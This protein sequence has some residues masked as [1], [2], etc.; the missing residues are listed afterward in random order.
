[1]GGAGVRPASPRRA[2]AREGC[3]PLRTP[4][5]P[6]AVEP[7][8]LRAPIFGAGV[9]PE[10]LA[11]GGLL[12]AFARAPAL[13]SGFFAA[14][15]ATLPAEE[16]RAMDDRPPDLVTVREAAR[17]VDRSPGTVRTWIRER[18]LSSWTGEGT[19]PGNAPILVSRAELL[20]LVVTEGAAAHPGRPP[21]SPSPSPVAPLDG[22][23][24]AAL[25]AELATV[26]GELATARAER[27][28]AR[29]LAEANRR[30]VAAVEAR[31]ADLAEALAV[32]RAELAGARAELDA[33]R[34]GGRLPWWRRLLGGPS[35]TSS[36]D[37]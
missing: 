20:A 24:V 13:D 29:E 25:R 36:G 17:L 23:A 33:L 28:G 30:T 27:D 19:G 1:M 2:R 18:R 11:G 4:A 21:A 5:G 32:A 7:R 8:A 15:R 16:P 22:G 14:G 31:A 9:R 26:R 37:A 12:S 10:A 3:T 6:I 34:A 35:P